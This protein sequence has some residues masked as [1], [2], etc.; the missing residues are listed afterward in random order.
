MF[1]GC[2]SIVGQSGTIYNQSSVQKSMANY[3]SG[4]LTHKEYVAD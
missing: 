2:T 4:Y 3:T 1:S